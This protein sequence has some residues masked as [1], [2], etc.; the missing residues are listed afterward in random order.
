MKRLLSAIFVLFFCLLSSVANIRLLSFN[1]AHGKRQG[2]EGYEEW[3]NTISDVIKGEKADIVFLQEVPIELVKTSEPLFKKAR[4]NNILDDFSKILGSGWC[5]F[6]TADYMI[7]RSVER[8]GESYI[9]GDMNQNNAILYNS[10]KVLGKDLADRLGFTKFDGKY[11]FDK[12]N[13]QAVEFRVSGNEGEKFVAIN[14]HAPF[15][16]LEH[17]SRDLAMLERLYASFKLKSGVV[18]A[19]DFNTA[20]KELL[21]RNFD[22][23][24]GEDSFFS[25]RSFGLK[26]S[27]SS[28]GDNIT[29][30]N[31]YDH[32]IYSR[33]ITIKKSMRRAF[34][35]GKESTLDVYVIGN[36][37]FFNSTELKKKVSDHLPI[38]IEI[39]L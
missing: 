22:F 33:K 29:L 39:S 27:I 3:I 30:A 1:I 31:D 24:D 21:G 32:F 9:Y 35:N 8:D 2:A 26:T 6:S 25:D 10:Q 12:N 18:I 34:V 38:V 13:V 17:R 5:Y 36:R 37:E 15:N 23:V 19:G 7:R 16:N 4:K 20:R 28:K 11:L 14:I